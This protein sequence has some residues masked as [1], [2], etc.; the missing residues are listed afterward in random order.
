MS[1]E[2]GRVFLS[3]QESWQLCLLVSIEGSKFFASRPVLFSF[4]FFLAQQ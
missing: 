1:V 3:D 2:Q 4:I